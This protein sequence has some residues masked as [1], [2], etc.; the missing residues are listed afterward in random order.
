M[1]TDAPATRHLRLTG[2]PGY[3]VCGKHDM[4]EPVKFAKS[5][6]TPSL[7]QECVAMAARSNR[8]WTRVADKVRAAKLIA[9]RS[10]PWRKN[11]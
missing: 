2:F 4:K 1:P 6:N 11:R 9:S 5:K 10:Q 3:T 7:C 8:R